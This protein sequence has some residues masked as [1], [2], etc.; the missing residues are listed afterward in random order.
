[1]N[2]IPE[3]YLHK[4][5][6]GVLG[7][8]I[9]V[10]LGRTFENWTYQQ[11]L[12]TLGPIHYYVH[13]K[14][15]QPCVVIDDD[16]S[17]T[18]TFIK[19]FEEHGIKADLSSEEIGKTWLNNV[20][21]K[22]SVFWWGG[23]GISTEHTAY[24]N[25]KKGILAP[26]SGSIDVNGQTL[27]EQIGAQIF[28]DGWA[29]V[30]PGN[31]SLAARLAQAAAR[32]S[33]D[34]E[35]VHAA[36][37]WAAMEAEAFVSK[38]IGHL[39]D[40]G[41]SFIPSASMVAKLISDIRGWVK[42]DGDWQ[43][44]RQRIEDEYGY[45]KYDGICHVIPN[46]GVMIL[47]LL[48]GGHSFHEAMHIV[49]TCGWDTDCNSG[50]VGCLV[51]IMHGFSGFDGGPN[52]RQPVADQA[53]ISSADN[54]AGIN[55][56]AQVA[57]EV[58][59]IGARLAG[60]E[61]PET[62]S[63][64]YHFSLPGSVQGFKVTRSPPG[65]TSIRQ[66]ES[67]G[68]AYLRIDIDGLNSD[69]EPIDVS[70]PT[71]TP[72][73]VLSVSRHYD[74]MASPLIY[75]VQK[76]QAI[77]SASDGN[78]GS[79]TVRL[80][81]KAYDAGDFLFD[82]EG[83]SATLN[84]GEST[85]LKWTVPRSLENKPIQQVGL[86]ISAD[87]TLRGAILLHSLTWTGTPTM[88]FRRPIADEDLAGVESTSETTFWERAWVRSIDK[89]H[90]QMG[91]SFYISQDRG[92]GI[93]SQGTKDWTDYRVVAQDFS[94]HLGAPAGVAVR[95]RGLNRWYAM[96][97]LQAGSVG[98]VKA[99]DEERTLLAAASFSW[100]FD[101]KYDVRLEVQGGEIRG[102]V[103]AVELTA[104]DDEYSGGAIGFVV[105][106]GALSADSLDVSGI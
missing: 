48:Y 65:L 1:M 105:T 80:L 2:A 85:K 62:P 60:Q 66:E 97:F 14:F 35:A 4:V 3:D 73:E 22:R 20:I 78:T 92:E 67:N 98:L 29:M 39:L 31:P 56:A 102:S 91:P 101:E 30:A 103:S 55:N 9:G 77:L 34:G 44:T 43:A 69:Q 50:N 46:H 86:A 28:I 33:H 24:L 81:L 89:F 52:W 32:V 19:A 37:L 26:R 70:T 11:I 10:C 57:F 68:D 76:I 79:A 51:A 88:T 8:L 36:M 49:N 53:L 27:A 75:P 23:N 54:G 95:V 25:L 15:N 93:I 40:T 47:A 13:E 71:F 7:K 16:I 99:R 21:E 104:V 83:E 41:L 74:M 82:T 61:P 45:H 5:Y 106:D 18:F 72:A 6:A 17:G 87:D 59:K 96:I 100:K 63:A 64:R 94:V 38:D 58:A 84:A 42:Q 12:K 90:T